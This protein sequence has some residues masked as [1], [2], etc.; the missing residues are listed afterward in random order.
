MQTHTFQSSNNNSRYLIELGEMEHPAN[1]AYML[2]KLVM[3][4]NKL[5]ILWAYRKSNNFF[6]VRTHVPSGFISNRHKRENVQNCSWEPFVIEKQLLSQP[7]S[8]FYPNASKCSISA[9]LFHLTTAIAT[10]RWVYCRLILIVSMNSHK[11]FR[12][13]WRR[14]KRKPRRLHH[15]LWHV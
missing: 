8:I 14:D 6:V 11:N 12:L 4:M 10:S 1:S 7:V 2:S 3:S 13:G 15:H 9:M 5:K